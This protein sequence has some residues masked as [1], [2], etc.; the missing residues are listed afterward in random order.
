MTE[1]FNFW[2]L[3]AGLGLFLFGMRQLESSL[4]Y[5]AGRRFKLFLRSFTQKPLMSVF[6][7]VVATVFVQSSSLVGLI[8][9]AL[10][11]AGIIPLKNAMGLS[12]APTWVLHLLAGLL[13]PW[14]LNL[15]LPR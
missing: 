5:L 15:T 12:L 8:V 13:L 1:Y 4:K 14:G 6:C 9:L 7:G 2:Q 3:L 11:G 10:V